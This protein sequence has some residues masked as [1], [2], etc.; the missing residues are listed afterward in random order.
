MFYKKLKPNI[1]K[2]EL[3]CITKNITNKLLTY[4]NDI[5]LQKAFD[6]LNHVL[7]EK[8][9]CMGFIKPIIKWFKSYLSN[10]KLFVLL[11]LVCSGEGLIT[12]GVPQGSILVPLLFLIYING[13]H[14]LYM[15]LLQIYMLMIHALIVNIKI[16]KKMK[17]F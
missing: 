10:R 9:E 4:Q 16:Y 5:D 2:F 17:L 3:L 6:T 14:K 11:E 12:C 8:M 13:L 1:E 15:K 7:L